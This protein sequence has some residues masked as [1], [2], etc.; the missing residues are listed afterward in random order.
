M[1]K[2]IFV[3]HL[4][5]FLDQKVRETFLVLQVTRKSR[6]NGE[7]YLEV[8]LRDATGEILGVVFDR[9]EELRPRLE[10]GQVV[11][12]SGEV[13]R[14][15]E[16]L[17]IKILD[18]TPLESYDIHDYLPS[19]PKDIRSLER[20]LHELVQ[21]VLNPYLR[22]LLEAFFQDPVFMEAFRL[23]PA[24]VQH[25]HAY[26]GG[27]LEHT[28]N[29]TRLARSVAERYREEVQWDV[30]LTGALLHDVGKVREYRIF[31]TFERTDEGRLLGHILLGYQMVSDALARVEEEMGSPFPEE[32]KQQVLHL[33][34][35]HHGELSYGSPQV[36]MTLEAQILHFVDNLDAKVWMFIEAR[37]HPKGEESAWSEYIKP[38]SRMVYIGRTEPKKKEERKEGTLF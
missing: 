7:P 17:Q 20:E 3:K 12:I 38:L 26:L 16:N 13:Y 24:A 35:S 33:I 4:E 31:P 29:V 6:R 32:L 11:E 10:K 23:A 19:T 25:H 14:L 27:L 2:Q 9:V 18:A 34:I 36:P 30:L 5:H 15:N 21:E 37:K 1:A 8:R 22:A 28:V